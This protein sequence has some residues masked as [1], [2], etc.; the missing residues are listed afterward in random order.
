MKTLVIATIVVIL[1]ISAQVGYEKVF[2]HPPESDSQVDPFFKTI[3]NVFWTVIGILTGLVVL[4]KV[5]SVVFGGMDDRQA[6]HDHLRQ[7]LDYLNADAYRK[8]EMAYQVKTP[9]M[10]RIAQ[11]ARKTALKGEI[12]FYEE[13]PEDDSNGTSL[14]R[15]QKDLYELEY[16]EGSPSTTDPRAWDEYN[17][18]WT[19][20]RR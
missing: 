18:K 4:K 7:G 14:R 1:L 6:R 3:G 12:E 10:T 5:L 20:G 11:K 9:E 2:G 19:G 15:A 8:A 16:Y 13:F 17:K